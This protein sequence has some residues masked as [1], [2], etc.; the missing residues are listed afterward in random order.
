MLRGYLEG[1][2]SFIYPF[3]SLDNYEPGKNSAYF[4]ELYFVQHYSDDHEEE[5][6]LLGEG[7]QESE[8]A[9]EFERDVYAEEWGI[10]LINE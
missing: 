10:L 5:Y 6:A 8:E 9:R 2:A 1:R 3:A 7:E 4:L